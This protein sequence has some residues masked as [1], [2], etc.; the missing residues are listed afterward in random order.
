MAPTTTTGMTIKNFSQ[1]IGPNL[2]GPQ[3]SAISAE[4]LRDRQHTCRFT[5][6][7]T[8]I[9][10][11]FAFRG[12]TGHLARYSKAACQRKLIVVITHRNHNCIAI[13]STFFKLMSSR[14]TTHG[15]CF[16]DRILAVTLYSSGWNCLLLVPK[17]TK[18]IGRLTLRYCIFGFDI[19][20]TVHRDKFA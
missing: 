9:S 11:T 19:I 12:L 14:F 5:S 8:R 20:W 7:V 6:C 17:E 2:S 1:E 15:T 4:L 16:L 3:E 13:W 18:H 10:I